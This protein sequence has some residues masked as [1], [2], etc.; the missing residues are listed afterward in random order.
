MVYSTI[1]RRASP[2]TKLR[3]TSRAI[4]R[5]YRS[6]PVRE[7]SSVCVEILQSPVT[8]LP[9]EDRDV[10]QDA[11]MPVSGRPRI[12]G[13]HAPRGQYHVTSTYPIN[14]ET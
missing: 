8:S 12:C 2:R 3:S 10:R 9:F 11:F 14:L 5:D 1:S 13:T 4:N 6:R 7:L